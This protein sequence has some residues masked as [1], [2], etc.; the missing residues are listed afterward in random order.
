MMGP[1][2]G[3]QKVGLLG[4]KNIQPFN[5]VALKIYPSF[6]GPFSINT[7]Y[8][9][10]FFAWLGFFHFEVGLMLSCCSAQLFVVA[11]L[12]A[13]HIVSIVLLLAIRCTHARI[14]S[15]LRAKA[16]RTSFARSLSLTIGCP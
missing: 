5:Y 3:M 11:L 15:S 2:W 14:M 10:I 12:H 9:G 7:R 6:W 8:S 13:S 1:F 4:G 16:L